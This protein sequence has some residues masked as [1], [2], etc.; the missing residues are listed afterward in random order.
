M[1]SDSVK[2]GI[3]RAPH[4]ALFKSMGYT[5]EELARPLIG[6]ASSANDIIPGHIHLDKIVEAVRTGILMAGGMP[7]VFGCIGVCDG[8]AM[9]HIGMKYSLGSRELIADSVEVMAIAH[10]FDGIVLVP[11][12]D[13]IVPGMLMAAARLDIPAVI[14]SGGPML[15]GTHPDGDPNHKIDLISVFEAVGAVSSGKMSQETLKEMEETACPTCGSCAGMFTANSMNCL[16]EAIGMALP[17]NGTIPAVMAA[18]IR[19]AKISGMKIMSLVEDQITPRKI[20]TEKAFKNAIAVDMALGC[21]TNTVLHLW[22]LARE[23]GITLDLSIINEISGKTPQLCSLSPA[24]SHHLEDLNRAGG[25]SAVLKE[26]AGEGLINE[27][28]LTVTGKRVGE[29]L[30]V[31][32]NSDKAVIKSTKAPYRNEGGLAALFGNI[33]PAGCVVKQA[34]VKESMLCHKGPARTF[35]SEEE[36]TEAIMNKRINP[37]EVLVIRYE[38]PKGGPG[39][40]EMLTPTSA[41]AGMGLDGEVAL[42]T[43][44]RFSGGT[45]GASIG[46]VSPEAM[47]GGPIAAIKDG[48]LIEI[49]IPNRKLNVMLSDEEIKARLSSCSHPAP[50]I[51]QGYMAR[52]AERVSSASEGAV[53]L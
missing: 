30:S 51:T 17:G 43:D 47:E 42:I 4:R 49:D 23:A 27:D 26:L 32:R 50:K 18:R 46:H 9:N 1:K 21:S 11:N 8:I 29:N 25:I 38:G 10:G 20:M 16:T 53:L 6:I 31:V 15:S 37:G 2:K 39:M 44:G 34:A 45:R 5:D 48:D 40:R 14:V 52:Y 36:A 7:V 24:G 41:I 35:N 3:E 22:A 19:N 12:C 13:K 28:C 33:A